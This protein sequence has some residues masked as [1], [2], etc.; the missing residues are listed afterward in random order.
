MLSEV[1]KTRK[2]NEGQVVR[3][4]LVCSMLR[5]MPGGLKGSG[6]IILMLLEVI[7][8]KVAPT[9]SQMFQ[10]LFPVLRLP[11]PSLCSLMQLIQ[12][13]KILTKDQR[14][15]LLLCFLR[16]SSSPW[17]S[18]T[19]SSSSPTSPGGIQSG[20]FLRDSN[21]VSQ[22]G[23]QTECKHIR[24]LQISVGRS[25][26]VTEERISLVDISYD[27]KK[28]LA[29]PNG[30]RL[31]MV[32]GSPTI[33]QLCRF[34]NNWGLKSSQFRI[35]W[36]S[37]SRCRRH[38]FSRCFPI[39]STAK[40]ALQLYNYFRSDFTILLIQHLR[41]S[42]YQSHRCLDCAWNWGK[43]CSGSN[44]HPECD[45]VALFCWGKG[46]QHH[47]CSS[48]FGWENS[49]NKLILIIWIESD[50][51]WFTERYKSDWMDFKSCQVLADVPVDSLGSYNPFFEDTVQSAPAE[52][53][54]LLVD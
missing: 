34:P 5:G 4:H 1:A 21:G 52:A 6:V 39:F 12:F 11:L 41:S 15:S 49:R 54:S 50:S 40:I 7:V 24:I 31:E 9:S 42:A 22:T 10:I 53:C 44:P 19:S 3:H 35:P 16:S 8:V 28:W 30:R 14:T 51:I 18:L 36:P 32:V 48:S 43:C 25:L 46:R 23:W 37:P 38:T 26:N 47:Q 45:L 20:R 17:R 27:G 29:G 13:W 2:F 33:F